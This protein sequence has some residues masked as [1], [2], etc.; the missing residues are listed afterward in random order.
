MLRLE[1]RSALVTGAARG[2]G[3][4][5]ALA[6]A[7]NGADVLVNTR[8]E[9]T[10][11]AVYNEVKKIAKGKIAKFRADVGDE[12]QV[13]AMF[14]HMINEFGKVN[15][16]V[17]NAAIGVNK[18]ILEY[19]TEFYMEHLRINLHSVYHISLRAVKEMIKRGEKG[20][21]INFSSIGAQ[22][23]HRQ[24]LAYD[25]SKGGVEAMTKAFALE[26][27]PWDITFNAVSP[28]SILGYF[29]KEM[30]KDVAERRNILDFA[31]PIPRQGTPRDVANLVL[32][33][34]SPESSYITGQVI[35]IDGGL[36][37]Q[38]RP[39]IISQLDITPDNIEERHLL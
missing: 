3:R 27:A 9:D 8:N 25:T 12:N 31:T 4:A 7:E 38:A 39:P 15:I 1:G 11:D 33:L 37:S 35:N 29:V 17:N 24:M 16:V 6:L 30:P 26:F 19:D 2:I 18:P 20:S 28:A 36:S 5:V 21:I 13:N 14:D 34:A 23:P 32:F 22:K 10:L